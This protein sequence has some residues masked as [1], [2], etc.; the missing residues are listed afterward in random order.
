ML[1]YKNFGARIKELYMRLILIVP[2]LLL[3][4][5]MNA[6]EEL[7]EQFGIEEVTPEMKAMIAAFVKHR[8]EIKGCVKGSDDYEPV[9]YPLQNANVMVT[10]VADTTQF[11]GA[12]SDETGKFKAY[13]FARNKL[14]DLSVRVKISYVGM[15]PY[16]KVMTGV[17]GKDKIGDKI[18]I[19]LDTVVLK[20][21]PV[22]LA[23]ATVIGELQK[24]Y[25]HG[26]TTI[27]NAGAY[28]MPSGSVLLDLVRRLP[29]L[30][31][32]GG[33]LT[34]LGESIEEIRL[35]GDSFFKHDINVALQNMPHDKIKSLKVYD[36]PDDTLDVNSDEHLVMDMQTKMA[37]DNLEFANASAG[38]TENLKNFLLMADGHT[39]V[40]DGAQIGLNL[41]A[42]DLPDGNTPVRRSVGTTVSASYERKFG[43]TTVDASLSHGYTR[44]DNE[45]ETFSQIYMPTYT[46]TT[47]TN[48]FSSNKQHNYN[49]NFSFD[50]IIKERTRW[51]MNLTLG[52]SDSKNLS[53]YDNLITNDAGDTISTTQQRSV[54]TG[55]SQNAQWNGIVTH[56][57]GEEK[58]DEIGLSASFGYT[59]NE[60]K[61]TSRTWSDFTQL[62]TE[63]LTDHLIDSPA[64]NYTAGSS[65][66]YNHN[67]G[68]KNNIQ[69]AYDF[70]Y[71]RDKN[72]ERYFDINP[73][74]TNVLVDSLSYRKRNRTLAHGPR[75][76]L[77]IDNSTLNLKMSMRVRPTRLVIDDQQYGEDNNR[78]A[79]NTTIYSPSTQLKFKLQGGE[80]SITLKYDGQNELPSVTSLSAVT[81]YSDP[82]NVYTGNSNLKE[83]FTHNAGLE[84]KYKSLLRATFDYGRTENQVTMLTTLDPLTGVRRTRPE[85]ING[86]W[87]LR[88][89]L[90]LTKQIGQVSFNAIALHQFTNSVSFVQ[91]TSDQEQSKTTTKYNNWNFAFISGYTNANLIAGLT[92]LYNID[93]HKN[94]YM[95]ESSNG[96]SFNATFDLMY[97]TTSGKLTL[98]TKF[99]FRK[100]FGYELASAN[101]THYIWSASAEYKFLKSKRASLK[102]DWNDILKSIDGFEA[103]VSDTQWNETRTIGKTSYLLLTFGYRLSLFN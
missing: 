47:N 23:E 83:A 34:Y 31:Y 50:G 85:N 46:Q 95:N 52:A 26:D 68:K 35:N 91:S 96:Q 27:F 82:M 25:Q 100:T 40:K 41:V 76:S 62:G 39:Y 84:I 7:L 71:D 19:D 20:S 80:S 94:K 8:F 58:K 66:Y 54:Q 29:G 43:N 13:I 59:N 60:S 48:S 93:N 81:D 14:K 6:Q 51:R 12:A 61:T 22:T 57:L 16:E 72:N 53:R 37:V 97:T 102:L 38:V 5:Q 49:G 42:R 10:C 55:N 11:G 63:Q 64:K 70:D 79:Y 28:E 33:K 73:D 45:T 2:F 36:V 21:M 18:V 75:A 99:M 67:F 24:M 69:L 17:P 44:T 9:P 92:A 101:D 78:S 30:R 103:S 98:A 90:F 88:S 65:V 32:E 15:E 89:Y 3:S 1:S 4:G 74:A 87:N 86:N 77:L 56:K